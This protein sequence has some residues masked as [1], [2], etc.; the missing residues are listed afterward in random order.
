MI[1]SDWNDCEKENYERLC[2][3]GTIDGL[4]YTAVMEMYNARKADEAAKFRED[5]IRDALGMMAE[6]IEQL[7]ILLGVNIKK[8]SEKHFREEM[9]RLREVCRKCKESNEQ[10]DTSGESCDSTAEN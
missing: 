5:K 8:M 3:C 4:A 2:K 6:G 10:A 7:E 9:A 1:H